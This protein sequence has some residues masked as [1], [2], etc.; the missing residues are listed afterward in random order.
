LEQGAQRRL[1]YSLLVG[2]VFDSGVDSDLE[3]D[4]SVEAE[5]PESFDSD[6]ADVSDFSAPS[7]SEPVPL[8]PRP[9]P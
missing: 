4:L 8:A 9:F 6:F 1:A 5:D 2:A 3:A 7:L